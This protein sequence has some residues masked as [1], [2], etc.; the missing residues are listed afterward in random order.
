MVSDTRRS[1]DCHRQDGAPNHKSRPELPRP[2][3]WRQHSVDRHHVGTNGHF[4]SPWPDIAL[5]PLTRVDV[6]KV[7]E[8]EAIR[9]TVVRGRFNPSRVCGDRNRVR[10][11]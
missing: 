5:S 6:A 11:R 10:D 1:A 4:C 2:T 3:K 8:I 7:K 9:P